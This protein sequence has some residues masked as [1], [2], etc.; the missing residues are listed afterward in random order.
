MVGLLRGLCRAIRASALP[1]KK[2]VAH[3]S[4]LRREL[5]TAPFVLDVQEFG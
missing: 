5:L 4:R 2:R 1:Q 3:C